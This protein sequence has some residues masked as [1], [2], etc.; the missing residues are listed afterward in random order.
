[1]ASVVLNVIDVPRY[2]TDVPRWRIK[3]RNGDHMRI[4]LGQFD[5]SLG[6]V[7]ANLDHMRYLTAEAESQGADLI[8][9]PE[10]ATH[11]YAFGEVPHI[12]RLDRRDRRLTDLASGHCD[13]LAPFPEDGDVHTYNSAAYLSHGAVVNL[14]RK[15]YLPNYLV[16]EERKHSSPGQ[17]LRAFDTTYARMATLICNDAWQ[18]MLPWLAAQ[19]GAEVLLVPTNSAAGDGR[20]TLDT[21]DYWRHLLVNIARMQ[22]CWV[23]FVNRV[24][25]EA[26]ARFWGGSQILDPTGAVVAKAALWEP[27]LI[28]VDIDVA[29]AGKRR[30]AIPLLADARLSFIERTVRRLIDEGGDA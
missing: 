28:T 21:I 11:G 30:R 24:G 15:L 19:D 14:H 4:A 6:D 27:E 9:F 18:P 26:G 13:V 1:M 7:A 8:V 17:S 22:Q 12:E 2:V 29:E 20:D 16:W 5:T 10:L 23:I 25:T 3:E